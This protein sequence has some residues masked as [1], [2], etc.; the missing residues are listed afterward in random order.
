MYFVV[1]GQMVYHHG[2]QLATEV[3]KVEPTHIVLSD[4]SLCEQVLL[5]NW[6]HRG[7]LTAAMMCELVQL[8]A[9]VFRDTV[10]A[11]V[12]MKKHFKRLCVGYAVILKQEGLELMDVN[13]EK[14][15]ISGLIINVLDRVG[16]AVY[17]EDDDDG[18]WTWLNKN[19]S[20]VQRKKTQ[21]FQD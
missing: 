21:F 1:A 13:L 15:V 3:V 5:S 6:T 8:D 14:H 10:K 12:D 20:K 18:T 16:H 2:F 11:N 17:P 7:L 9:A 19:V 4:Q